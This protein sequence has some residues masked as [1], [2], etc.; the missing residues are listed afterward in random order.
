[1]TGFAAQWRQ[2]N[3]HRRGVSGAA[4]RPATRQPRPAP[5][6]TDLSELRFQAL[7]L[8]LKDVGNTIDGSRHYRGKLKGRAFSTASSWSRSSIAVAKASYPFAPRHTIVCM[9]E[10]IFR[11]I[12]RSIRC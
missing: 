9:A 12:R 10:P 4:T 6:P 7:K 8:V 3:A 11:T 5:T 1:M 2:V